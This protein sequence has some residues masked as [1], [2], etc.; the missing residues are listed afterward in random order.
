[1]I[2]LFF[3]DIGWCKLWMFLELAIS[4]QKDFVLW[5]RIGCRNKRRIS[6]RMPG[7]SS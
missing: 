6:R 7:D 4:W 2:Y 5:W 1:M 3:L